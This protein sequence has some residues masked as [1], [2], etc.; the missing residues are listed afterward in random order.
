MQVA[1]LIRTTATILAIGGLTAASNVLACSIQ[2]LRGTF[3][4]SGQSLALFPLP[5]T[6]PTQ[7]NL[8]GAYTPF[9]VAGSATF[10]GDGTLEGVD[11]VNLGFGGVPRTYTGTYT[12]DDPENCTFAVEYT[13]V[14]SLP[15]ATFHF[16]VVP[17]GGGKTLQIV[18]T[19]PGSVLAFSAE[20]R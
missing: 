12:V 2:A 5:S 7:P 1:Q 6:P 15:P 19:D 20:R 14:S 18:E 8:I 17:S 10:N 11:V 13:P 4:Y 9:A 3:T 16:H